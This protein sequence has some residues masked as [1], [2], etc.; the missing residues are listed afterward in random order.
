MFSAFSLKRIAE[1]GLSSEW[2]SEAI[3]GFFIQNAK[4]ITSNHK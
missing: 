3:I 1:S 4:K 2:E